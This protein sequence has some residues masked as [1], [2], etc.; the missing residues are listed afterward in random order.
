ML[1]DHK[2]A[3]VLIYAH[4]T[5][6]KQ[7][8]FITGLGCPVLPLQISHYCK[9][10]EYIAYSCV[11]FSI[12][13]RLRM[14]GNIRILSIYFRRFCYLLFFVVCGLWFALVFTVKNSPL[15]ADTVSERTAMLPPASKYQEP[16][17][18]HPT[19]TSYPLSLLY[20]F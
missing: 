9:R 13:S 12:G 11:N 16:K 14:T 5:R 15:A 1:C 18:S 10:L 7:I 3:P 17:F 8:E 19:P 20:F 4:C 2:H 6:F